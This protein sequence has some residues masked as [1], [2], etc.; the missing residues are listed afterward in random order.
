MLSLVPL[1]AGSLLHNEAR[2][3]RRLKT[4]VWG[5]G[6]QASLSYCDREKQKSITKGS[7]GM[8]HGADCFSSA[9]HTG[10][11]CTCEPVLATGRLP[12][13]A[14]TNSSEVNLSMGYHFSIA[15]GGWGS[16]TR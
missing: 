9:G 6:S 8:L 1:E 12:S 5:T 3:G 2:S 14:S 7:R 4:R 16:G 10:R 11:C 15:S 13:Q